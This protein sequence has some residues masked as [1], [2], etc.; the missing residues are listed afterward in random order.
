MSSAIIDDIKSHVE[1]ILSGDGRMD[2]PGF[3][4]TKATY[5]FMEEQ[6]DGR[7]VIMEHGDKRQ[8]CMMAGVY[9]IHVLLIV[10][11]VFYLVNTYII[12]IGQFESNKS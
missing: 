8:V 6:G 12:C 5:S 4:A 9:I 2:S 10:R 3:S 1:I 11:Y 7:V